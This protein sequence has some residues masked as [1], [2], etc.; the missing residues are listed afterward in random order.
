[1]LEIKLAAVPNQ[2]FS[3][4]LDERFYDFRIVTTADCCAAVA[5]SRDGEVLVQGARIVPGTPLLPYRYQESGNF[6]LLTQDGDLP[7]YAQ[8]GNTQV[9]VYLA[10]T[11][12]SELRG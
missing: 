6:V 2:E 9:L 3:A 1:M 4:T 12:L 7:D 8:F 10:E 5:I 11:E